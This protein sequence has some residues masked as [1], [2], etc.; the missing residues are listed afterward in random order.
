MTTT[1]KPQPRTACMICRPDGVTVQMC[2]PCGE[3][4]DRDAHADGSVAE[5]MRWAA[6]RAVRAREQE[7]EGRIAALLAIYEPR[8]PQANILIIMRDFV[9]GER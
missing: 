3:S 9:R 2:R 6:D 4:Y 8:S 1:P 7:I 5:A